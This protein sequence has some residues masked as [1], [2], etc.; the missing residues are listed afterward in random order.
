[1][2]VAGG[3][4]RA[5]DW[6]QFLGPERHGVAG[7]DEK[8]AKGFPTSGPR[9]LWSKPV[10]SGFAGPVVVGDRVIVFH[11]VGDKGIVEAVGPMSGEEQWRF[12]YEDSYADSFGFDDG[13]RASPAVGQG[14][15]I[16]HGANGMV[17]ALDLTNGKALWNYDSAVVWSSPQG[18][19]G[20]A[21]TP[22]IVGDKV[23]LT[24]GGKDAK[25]AAGVVC[26]NLE[27]GKVAWQGI[28]DEASYAAPIQRQLAD[29]STAL[30]CWMRNNL[31]V[32]KASDGT[33]LFQQR[34]RSEMDASVNAATP[35][36]CGPD[37]LFTTACYDVGAAL[38]KWNGQGRLSQLWRKD[39]VLDC[40]YSTP[41]YHDGYLYGL[42][43]R[44]E[45]GQSLRCIRVE[46][47]KVMWESG[48][49]AGGTL[50]LADKTLLLLTEGGELWMIEATPEGFQRRASEQLLRGGHRSYGAL[51]KGIYY[52]RDGSNLVA[53]DL[54]PAK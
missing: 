3:S 54:R 34:L 38:W 39:D 24:P 51:S 17:Q 45:F 36:F 22:L 49:V 35:I 41:V 43:G 50:M 6:P 10:G 16:V 33:S 31:T 26:L 5:A 14:K 21:C 37:R 27:D 28:A 4:L 23:V 12:T 8:I 30:I 9:I 19:F 18:F 52:A 11:R 29:G 47:G 42:H 15:V 1:M 32:C 25:G 40:H 48:K 2:K 46:D 44:Q 20:R 13:P 53:V 7:A